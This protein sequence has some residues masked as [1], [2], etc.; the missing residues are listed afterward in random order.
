MERKSWFL[1]GRVVGLL[2]ILAI[3][4]SGPASP[5][6]A[7]HAEPAALKIVAALP[8]EGARKVD[9]QGLQR[10]MRMALEERS[11][12]LDGTTVTLQM[13]DDSY[14]G[15][16]AWD[17]R[18]ELELAKR[19]AADPAV[20]AYVGP[21]SS[22]AARLV[23]PVLNQAGLLEIGPTNSY[24]GLTHTVPGG[25]PGEPDAFYPTGQRSYI[26][27]M[28]ADDRQA[29]AGAAWAEQL[30]ARR[31]AVL[32]DGSRRG[33][34]FAATFAEAGVARGLELAG[35]PK[36]LDPDEADYQTLA[37]EL[38]QTADLVYLAIEDPSDLTDLL[39]A[40]RAAGGQDLKLLL[41]DSAFTRA[42]LDEADESADGVYVTSPLVPPQALGG[43]AA[44]W[45]ARYVARFGEE[46]SAF[47]LYAY[48]AVALALDAI[49]RAGAAGQVA[50]R[51]SVRA[52]AFQTTAFDGLLGTYA[53]DPTGDAS[54]TII[55]GR[56]VVDGH[57]DEGR[58]VLLH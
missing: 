23:V 5:S 30:G 37:L 34:L 50:D 20:V 24:P 6:A 44:D 36:Q 12:D 48:D 18:R 39:A 22:A 41:P 47:G 19:A 55:F 1:G 14:R 9:M 11:A 53:I 26:R 54:P 35:P 16:G 52:A 42:F 15:Q 46:P 57:F 2:L 43:A 49:R 31:V 17:P 45:R 8:L 58:L 3:L 38:A 56:R 29:A 27:L 21:L 40:L 7:S 25:A 28:P 10:A 51:T 13:A 32:Q 33:A 4:A